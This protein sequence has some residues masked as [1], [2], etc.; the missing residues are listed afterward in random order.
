MTTPRSTQHT[1]MKN[2]Y[3]YFYIIEYYLDNLNVRTNKT[4][5]FFECFPV[6][7]FKQ[8]QEQEII[9]LLRDRKNMKTVY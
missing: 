2:A 9:D 8:K 4:F 6:L 1:H 3:N 7:L 5:T